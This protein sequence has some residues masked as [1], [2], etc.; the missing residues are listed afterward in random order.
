MAES[1]DKTLF[2]DYNMNDAFDWSDDETP[3]RDAI[4][5]YLMEQNGHDTLKT[6]EQMKPFMSMSED[7]V[8]KYVEDNLKTAAA[9]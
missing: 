7:D 4:W 3:V 2:I 5:D 1:V 6:E 8:R 9:K